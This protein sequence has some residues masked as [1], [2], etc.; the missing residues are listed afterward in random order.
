MIVNTI[1]PSTMPQSTFFHKKNSL[2]PHK[3]M[4]PTIAL[5]KRGFTDE[6]KV[7]QI[8]PQLYI[9]YFFYLAVNTSFWFIYIL[10][11]GVGRSKNFFDYI[12]ILFRVL[13]MRCKTQKMENSKIIPYYSSIVQQRHM[14]CWP[15]LEGLNYGAG[16][17]GKLPDNYSH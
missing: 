17:K 6:Y 7:P 1:L 16:C 5:N 15:V 4:Y 13:F 8:Q 14:L 10:F 3:S 11:S 2:G 12:I 9:P